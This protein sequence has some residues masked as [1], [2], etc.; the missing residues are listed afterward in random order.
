MADNTLQSVLNIAQTLLTQVPTHDITPALITEKVDIAAAMIEGGREIR[1][2]AVAALLYLIEAE[3]VES[4]TRKKL[5]TGGSNSF[6]T[7]LCQSIR[8]ASE[9]D[10]A[11][12]F[13]TAPGLRLLLPDLHEALESNAHTESNNQAAKLRVLTSDYLDVTDP[14]ALRLLLLLQEKG[15]DVRIYE[16]ANHSFHMKAYL[17][18]Y[19][20]KDCLQ[21]TAFIGSS[22]VTTHPQFS[23]NLPPL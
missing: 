21:G 18:T 22:N 14:D 6:L 4:N 20:K 8:K 5:I 9:I 10:F 19:C 16:T 11:V 1:R 17:F 23:A 15:A 7:A 12:A 13:I 2:E 3:T